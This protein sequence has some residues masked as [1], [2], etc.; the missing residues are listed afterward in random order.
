MRFFKLLVACLFLSAC[1][2]GTS[3]NAKF[4]T[5]TSEQTAVVSKKCNAFIGVGRVQLPKYL[6]RPQIVTQGK[7]SPEMV[8]SEYNRWVE[9]PAVLTT[10]VLTEDLSAL[11]PKAQIKM[12][13]NVT[14]KFD[15]FVTVEVVKM[16]AVL[17]EKA[18]M[19]AWFTIKDN[20]GKLLKRQK[21]SS[22]LKI[23]KSYDDL[24][25]GY[26]M[27]WMQLS[28]NIAEHLAKSIS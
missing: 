15:M 26:S 13:Q 2:F 27:L 22:E 4:Y 16:N 19:E 1:I 24:I 28:K 10:R 23:G 6:D 17:S 25:N 12:R 14:E 11:L 21:F 8:I 7:D 3:Q 18:Q 5:L 20:T 9:A